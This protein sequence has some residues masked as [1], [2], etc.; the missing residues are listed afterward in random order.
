MKFVQWCIREMS[1]Q[2]VDMLELI[3]KGKAT[4][5]SHLALNILRIPAD[6]DDFVV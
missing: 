5:P 2:K 6:Y 1:Q 3:K 4:A